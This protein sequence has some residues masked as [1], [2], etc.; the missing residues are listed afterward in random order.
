MTS[1]LLKDLLVETKDGDW[2]KET[3]TQDHSPR[4]VIRGADFPD[5][6]RGQVGRVP[7]RYLPNRTVQR[8]TLSANDILLETAGGTHG[9][10]TG[11]T[12]LVTQELLDA[13]P[14]PVIGA[15]FTRFLRVDPS[16]M[17]PRY[18]YWYLR[19]IYDRGEMAEYHVQHTGVG[20]FQYTVFASSKQIP[21]KPW[22]EQWAIAEVLGALDEKIAANDRLILL[23]DELLA[24]RLDVTA[25]GAG[26]TSLSA[27][28]SV[29]VASTR[30]V[31]GGS[32]RYIDI[33]AVRQGAYDF[34]PV[35]PWEQAPGRARRVVG[36][37]DTIWSTV[38]PNRRS[39][40]L[41]LDE[42]PLLIASTGLAVLHPKVGRVA[43]L[44]E[45]TRMPAFE[46]YLLTV[47]EGSAY[48]AVRADR[49]K[50]A[51]VP[52][53]ANSDWDAFE[54]FAWPLRERA[55]AAAVESRSLAATRDELLPL[56]MSGKVRVKDAE[57]IVEEVV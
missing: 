33:A 16:L 55:H 56:L 5:V 53:L 35:T 17:D 32:L 1:M 44:Y 50:D 22:S 47:A 31:P 49:F 30:P 25:R 19:W 12:V 27:L 29:N 7:L 14:E 3:P 34:P 15:S 2:G 36:K 45:A 37:G 10:P 9:R 4:Y 28:A 39:H 46:A 11:R 13:M 48:P 8:R 40:A 26:F 20:R 18:L 54:A 41:I 42:D 57:K 23:A 6:A 38:R 51:P 43:C 21:L 24:T 52:D